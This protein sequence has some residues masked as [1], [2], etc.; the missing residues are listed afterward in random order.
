[1]LWKSDKVEGERV[2]V[3]VV[4]T[5]GPTAA[6]EIMIFLRPVEAEVVAS[7]CVNSEDSLE[8]IGFCMLDI[9]KRINVLAAIEPP[10]KLK[11][12]LTL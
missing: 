3:V 6:P 7:T 1:M 5:L 9:E 11:L 10:T 2:A 12:T 4:L 8:L